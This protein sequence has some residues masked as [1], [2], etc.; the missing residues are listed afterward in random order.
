MYVTGWR[1]V[2]YLVIALALT[3]LANF[4]IGETL[5]GWSVAILGAAFFLYGAAGLCPACYL[6]GCKVRPPSGG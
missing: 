5:L 1:R 2:P 3:L 6:A 4:Y